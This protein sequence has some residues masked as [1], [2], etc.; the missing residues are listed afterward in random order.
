MR[1]FPAST[2]ILTRYMSFMP[3]FYTGKAYVFLQLWASDRIRA[4]A[5]YRAKRRTIL[6]I[7][8]GAAKN[9][10]PE[11]KSIVGIGMDAPKH[12]KKNSED[13]LLL[14]CGD[15]T[16]S[17]RKEYQDL[18][19]GW[20]FFRSPNLRAQKKKVKEFVEPSDLNK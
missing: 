8:C 16:E 11:M 19:E 7:A 20:N 15:W 1:N 18:N 4:E 6:E 2:E 12:A 13:F 9:A 10:F 5:D 14:E 3:S 17:Q